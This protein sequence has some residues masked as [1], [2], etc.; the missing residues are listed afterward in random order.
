M[1]E[2]ARQFD[3]ARDTMLRISGAIQAL[4]ELLAV[5]AQPAAWVRSGVPSP[6]AEAEPLPTSVDS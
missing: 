2:L 4:E 5:G 1:E 6:G 3:A